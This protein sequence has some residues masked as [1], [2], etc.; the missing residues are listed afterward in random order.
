MP[1]YTSITYRDD[2][3]IKE[4]IQNGIKYLVSG[5]CNFCGKCCLFYLTHGYVGEKTALNEKC[6]DEVNKVCRIQDKKPVWC[7]NYPGGEG[8]QLMPKECSY[9]ITRAD[10]GEVMKYGLEDTMAAQG[11]YPDKEGTVI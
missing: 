5:K 4:F 2:G 1:L 8:F 7:K 11:L 10:T 6:F 3:D 9:V